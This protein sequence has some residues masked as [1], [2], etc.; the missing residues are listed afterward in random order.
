VIVPD[1][2]PCAPPAANVPQAR[3]LESLRSR[4]LLKRSKC[5]PAPGDTHSFIADADYHFMGGAA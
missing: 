3:P 2:P 1:A 5:G 4:W